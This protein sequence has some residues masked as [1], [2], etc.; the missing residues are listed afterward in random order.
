MTDITL[1][2]IEI[3]LQSNYDG[4]IF[5]SCTGSNKSV[6]TPYQKKQEGKNIPPKISFPKKEFCKTIRV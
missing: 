6:V 3:Q 1:P 4:S 5:S 2:S